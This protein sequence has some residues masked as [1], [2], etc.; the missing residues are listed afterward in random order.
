MSKDVTVRDALRHARAALQ[1]SQSAALDA[2]VLLAGVLGCSRSAFYRDPDLALPPRQ[3]AD[4]QALLTARARG[5]P[6]AYLT[7]R[8][9]FWSLP[10]FITDAVLIPRPETELVV[11]TALEFSG[12]KGSP[13]VLDLGTGSGAI[14]AAYA[15]EHPGARVTAS[16]RSG[17]ALAVAK[18]NFRRLGCA[19]VSAVRGDWLAPFADRRVDLILAN[20]PYIA[21]SERET[22]APELRFEPSS[23]LFSAAKGLNDL[24][25]IIG[26]ARRVLHRGGMLVVEHGAQQGQSVRCVFRACGYRD[27]L[28]LHD[29][30]GN[31]RVTRASS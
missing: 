31:E 27:I 18:E 1:G 4:F 9:E 12:R 6:V 24:Q 11:E 8:A 21:E 30:S 16:D 20:P 14:A 17:A 3:R 26:G 13:W 10:L 7:G 2:E 22:L 28:T 15:R 5:C 19:N 29:L 23:A 25:S